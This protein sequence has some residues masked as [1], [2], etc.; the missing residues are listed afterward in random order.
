MKHCKF[1]KHLTCMQ[2]SHIVPLTDRP[3]HFPPLQNSRPMLEIATGL[4]LHATGLQCRM[5]CNFALTCLFNWC[6]QRRQCSSFPD[7]VTETQN[8][9]KEYFLYRKRC[10]FANTKG[11]WVAL[12]FCYSFYLSRPL[13]SLNTDEI[14]IA[15]ARLLINQKL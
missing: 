10:F 8:N 7:K 6:C 2:L 14:A 9:I 15:Q 11:E 12:H 4:Q 1:A 13:S 5:L 3:C